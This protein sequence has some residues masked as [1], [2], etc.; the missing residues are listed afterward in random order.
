MIV[1]LELMIEA[2]NEEGATV[3]FEVYF[4]NLIPVLCVLYKNWRVHFFVNKYSV[5]LYCKCVERN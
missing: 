2:F 4:S 5:L 3:V 1:V